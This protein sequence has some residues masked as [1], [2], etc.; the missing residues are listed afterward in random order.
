VRMR[1]TDAEIIG[2]DEDEEDG[3]GSWIGI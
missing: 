3:L 2:W 1:V